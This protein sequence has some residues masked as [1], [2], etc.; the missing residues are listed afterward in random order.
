MMPRPHSGHHY[1]AR[2]LLRAAAPACLKLEYA[3]IRRL[4]Q[5]WESPVGGAVIVTLIVMGSIALA[6]AL[7]ENAY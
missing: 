2:G 5:A 6:K 4:Q 3:F 7:T 1:S